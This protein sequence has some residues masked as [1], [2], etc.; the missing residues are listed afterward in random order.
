MTATN[1][2]KTPAMIGGE[3]RDT[4]RL[5]TA[6][7]VAQL[8]SYEWRPYAGLIEVDERASAIFGLPGAGV[9]SDADAFARVAPDHLDRNG[10]EGAVSLMRTRLGRLTMVF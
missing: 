2:E 4:A 6:L 9:Y 3:D 1:T 5:E 8:G 10:R 7:K